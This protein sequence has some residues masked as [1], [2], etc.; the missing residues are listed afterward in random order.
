MVSKKRHRNGEL[1]ENH[2][3][4]DDQ[5]EDLKA[6]KASGTFTNKEVANAFG[7]SASLVSL[8]VNGHRRKEA[9][10]KRAA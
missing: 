5:V 3:L 10:F 7:V 1:K 8:I 6:M 2:K 4:T 9:T